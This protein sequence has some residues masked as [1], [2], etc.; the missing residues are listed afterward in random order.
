MNTYEIL[1][2]RRSVRKFKDRMV[3]TPVIRSVLEIANF[4]PSAGNLQ[5]R[6]VIVVEDEETR[7]KL[8]SA[9]LDQRFVFEVPIVFVVL[10]DPKA[11][12]VKYGNRGKYL[13]ALQDATIFASYLL[14]AGMNFGLGS[15]WVG[16]FNEDRVREILDIEEPMR[17]IALIPMGYPIETPSET[18]RKDVDELIIKG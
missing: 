9:A 17:P 8:A 4:S 5:A 15:C 6:R 1:K 18:P 3:P 14:L 12:A 16:A 2:A 13:Y 10:T 7:R 11:S